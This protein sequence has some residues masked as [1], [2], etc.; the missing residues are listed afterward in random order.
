MN[1]LQH[2][3]Q[4]ESTLRIRTPDNYK[5][6]KIEK[7]ERKILGLNAKVESECF[8]KPQE[9]CPQAVTDTTRKW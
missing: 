8:K 9:I 3:C 6:I 4:S 2:S 7:R 1:T 5:E